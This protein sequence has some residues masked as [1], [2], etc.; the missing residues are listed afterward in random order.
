MKICINAKVHLQILNSLPMPAKVVQHVYQQFQQQHAALASSNAALASA[1]GA[2]AATTAVGTRVPP[3]LS[4]TSASFL[5]LL[6]LISKSGHA[7]PL[8]DVRVAHWLLYPG[9]KE[10]LPLEAY[11]KWYMQQRHQLQQAAARHKL[12]DAI[13]CSPDART[14]QGYDLKAVL[15]RQQT[16]LLRHNPYAP[17]EVP[18][19]APEHASWQQ[20]SY[21]RFRFATDAAGAA[22]MLSLLPPLQKRLM[23]HL[24]N[25]S[26]KQVFL[27]VEMPMSAV[28]AHIEFFGM[29]FHAEML[30]RH[31]ALIKQRLRYLWHQARLYT[32]EEVNLDSPKMFVA[33]MQEQL[34]L[35]MPAWF[36]KQQTALK[37]KGP[38]RDIPKL[39]AELAPLHPFPAIVME[40]RRLRLSLSHFDTLPNKAIPNRH[41]GMARIHPTLL[42]NT[43][44]GRLSC[45]DPNLQS[46]SKELQ[47]N[48]VIRD[49]DTEH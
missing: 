48:T 43:H 42:Q 16:A 22:H 9:Q 29:G 8:Q 27:V 14:E 12:D 32:H 21:D 17:S 1:D 6:Y 35:P 44:T 24:S 23:Q 3:P 47:Y 5:T 33:A 7:M 2:T 13:P 10:L 30:Q 37:G 4:S 26:L 19:P 34:R 20:V 31:I 39:L 49:R 38:Y 28:L 46:V 36:L 18:L 41:L 11:F 45:Q 25:A 15:Q 40:L